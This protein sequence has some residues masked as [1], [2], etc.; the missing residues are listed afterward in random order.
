MLMQLVEI[1]QE[2]I[3]TKKLTPAL[4]KQVE[5]LLLST[6][7]SPAEMAALKQLL[8]AITNGMVEVKE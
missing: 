1:V 8:A 3:A 4:D 2:A 5:R 7:L 6:R